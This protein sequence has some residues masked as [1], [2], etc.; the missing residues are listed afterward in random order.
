ML[1]QTSQVVLAVSAMMICS[2]GNANP[3]EPPYETIRMKS[4]DQ[5]QLDG[6]IDY[7]GEVIVYTSIDA[8]RL[9]L[10]FP[11]CVSGVSESARSEIESLIGHKARIYAVVFNVQPDPSD[12]G[13][14][15]RSLIDGVPI[16]NW[17][18]GDRALRITRLERQD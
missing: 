6:I 4:G 8:K 14:M 13:L 17:C 11:Y 1:K 16:K 7:R 9:R 10:V 18:L 12:S 5:I 15:T 2:A 3:I